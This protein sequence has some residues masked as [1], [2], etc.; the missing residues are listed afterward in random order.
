LWQDV[1]TTFSKQTFKNAVFAERVP[2][3]AWLIE[4]DDDELI[5]FP[6]PVP[7]FLTEVDALG[8]NVVRGEMVDHI[9]ADCRL[10]RAQPNASLWEQYPCMSNVTKVILKA[11]TQKKAIHKGMRRNTSV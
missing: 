7:E 8:Y 10:P 6:K 11:T 4:T 2:R 5:E 3:S 1:F 9:A